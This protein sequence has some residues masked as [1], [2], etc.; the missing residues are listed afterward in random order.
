MVSYNNN[1]IF[2]E[3]AVYFLRPWKLHKQEISVVDIFSS[4]T[5]MCSGLIATDVL[6]ASSIVTIIFFYLFV[7]LFLGQL[8]RRKVFFLFTVI[9][10][11]KPVDAFFFIY[12]FFA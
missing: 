7:C 2:N 10:G 6:Y 8:V 9:L 4:M 12:E 5:Y 3:N 11:I 1:N